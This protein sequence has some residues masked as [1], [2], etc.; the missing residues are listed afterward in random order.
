VVVEPAQRR[1]RL[2]AHGINGPL[3]WAEMEMSGGVRPEGT[4]PQDPVQWVI[5]MDAK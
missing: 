3:T 4:R 5:A 2:L 1:V